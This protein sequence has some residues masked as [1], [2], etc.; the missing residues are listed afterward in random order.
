MRSM[1][2]GLLIAAGLA[3]SIV[4]GCS[5]S[6]SCPKGEVCSS[7]TS[8]TSGTGATS[9]TT[10]GS[11]TIFHRFDDAATEASTISLV[12][13]GT[14]GLP[15]TQDS[16]CI[17]DSGAGINKCS[18]D[19]QGT[20]T[21][22]DVTEFATPVCIVPPAA[23]GNCDPGTN[24][25]EIQFCDGDPNDPN[26]PGVCVALTPSAPMTGQGV[27]LPKCTFKIDGTAST[28][29]VGHDACSFNTYIVDT[30]NNVTGIGICQSACRVNA[31]CS[32]LGATYGC[33]PDIGECST[34]P[35]A[36]K[37]NPGDACT[38][39]DTTNG[40]CFCA[41]GTGT[42]GFCTED[43]IVGA[44]PTGCPLGWVCDTGE[45]TVLDFGAGAPT[46]PAL[47]TQT[48]GGLGICLPTCIPDGG[49]AA[50]APVETDGGALDGSVVSE[51]AASGACPGTSTCITGDIVGSDCVPQ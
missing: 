36:R 51:A 38:S 18:S 9:G 50:P 29:C 5:S 8:G 32:A 1:F 44:S 22:V 45:P 31:D 28:G 4:S 23:G 49:A 27:C 10:A 41:T 24:V 20:Y 35:I 40:L 33:E 17:G 39:A 48:V 30:S 46:F 3:I 47:T 43:C 37:K 2:F 34:A 19:Y 15:C 7:A 26:S 42:T 14:T 21:D 13:D 12:A 25:D 11:G 6:T 16:D